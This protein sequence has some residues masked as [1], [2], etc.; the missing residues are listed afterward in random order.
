MKKYFHPNLIVIYLI[1]LAHLTHDI[2]TSFLPVL[3]PVLIKNFGIS[4]TYAAFFSVVLRIP[5]LLNPIIGRFSDK[6]N[7]KYFIII[8]IIIT[9]SAMCLIGNVQSYILIIILLFIAGLSSAFF[10]VPAPVL[11]KKLS[12]LICLILIH[13]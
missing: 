6:L 11:I 10:H 8:P 1:S 13:T 4:L 9:A 12:N 7:L 3:L 5:S 2:Y